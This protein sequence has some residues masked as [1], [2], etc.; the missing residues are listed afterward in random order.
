MT[1][2]LFITI[3][4]IPS[5]SMFWVLRQGNNSTHAWDTTIFWSV[6]GYKPKY[7]SVYE[8]N[9]STKNR[10][11]LS[12]NILFASNSWIRR[13]PLLLIKYPLKSCEIINLF[14]Q[15]KQIEISYEIQPL[16]TPLRN[17][18]N[19]AVSFVHLRIV[20]IGYRIVV[21]AQSVSQ[22]WQILFQLWSNKRHHVR[23]CFRQKT[24][25]LLAVYM[26]RNNPQSDQYFEILIFLFL[27]QL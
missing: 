18:R 14:I 19:E 7:W 20:L 15:K 17:F 23:H 26:H 3:L 1:E 11:E 12:V 21:A 22:H 24:K 27:P 5:D 25:P 10:R 2:I 16:S 8:H 9:M 4:T 6:L 13:N